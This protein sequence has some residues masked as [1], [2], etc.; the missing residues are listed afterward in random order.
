MLKQKLDEFAYLSYKVT[1][2]FPREEIYGITSQLRRASL[3]VVLNYI[4]GYARLGDNQLKYFLQMSYGSLKETKYLLYFSEREGYVEKEDYKKL[5]NLSE[6][7][8]AML[9]TTIKGIKDKA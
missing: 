3:S 2:N 4:E 6:E 5:I 9:W 8:G 1:K 7:I